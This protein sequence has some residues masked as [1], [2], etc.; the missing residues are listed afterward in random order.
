AFT[1]RPCPGHLLLKLRDGVEARAAIGKPGQSATT[2]MPSLDRLNATF[3]VHAF[4]A[5][6]PGETHASKASGGHDLA[7]YFVLEFPPSTDL[8]AIRRAYAAD[9][10]V[11]VAEFDMMMPLDREPNDLGMQWHLETSTGADA[12]LTGGWNHA[13]GDA[14]T[15]LAIA[16]SGVD[17]QHPDLAANIWINSV[18]ANGVAG[19]DDDGNGL[20]DDIRGWDFVSA[21]FN[22][23]PGED[24]ATPDNDPSDFNGH[25][26]HVAGIADAVTDNAL[27]VCG[28]GWNCKIMALRIGG[29]IVD[30]DGTEQ[31][32]VMMSAAAAAVN[33]ARQKGA[34]AFNCSWGSSNSSGLGA[35]VD[36]AVSQ[37]MV[38][39]VAAGN[40]ASQ[41][42]SYLSSRGDCF[43]VAATD[44]GD[45]IASFSN[46]GS[47]ID[48]CAPGVGIY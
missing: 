12:H 31:G 27:G 33:Y 37:G 6:F 9:P 2:G 45:L 18:E 28:V 41:A 26:T 14:T 34:A 19:V 29:S 5:Q 38:I 46:Y 22:P 3:R 17:W 11:E 1:P 39:C 16:D 32:V 48:V 23:W 40:D 43:D 30:T 35:A 21:L 42:Q 10:S 15:L 47:W 7:D 25:G 13:V 8:E 20:V 36:L 24:A 44:Q 4:A